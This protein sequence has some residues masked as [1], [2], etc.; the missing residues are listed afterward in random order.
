MKYKKKAGF[1]FIKDMFPNNEIVNLN[2]YNLR[3]N[4]SRKLQGIVNGIPAVWRDTVIQSRIYNTPVFPHQTV[5][6]HNKD[7]YFNSLR[8][9][10]IYRILIDS[11]IRLPAGVLRWCEDIPLTNPEIQNSFVFARLCSSSVFDIVFQYK[12]VTQILPT[13]KYLKRYQ[14][15]DSDLCCKCLVEEDSVLHCL[16]L[17]PRLVPYR[18]NIF[19]F[20]TNECNMSKDITMVPYFFGFKDEVGLN[21]ILLELKKFFF[22]DWKESIG[23]VTFCELFKTRIM[24]IIIKEKHLISSVKMHENFVSKWKNYKGFYDFLGPDRQIIT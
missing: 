10:T 16:W 3:N 17:C 5:H 11:K 6:L 12:I 9:D 14:V 4:K 18:E 7:V 8:A 13:K 20:I 23:V 22:Y 2:Y 15:Q 1:N 19:E 24:K 21:H